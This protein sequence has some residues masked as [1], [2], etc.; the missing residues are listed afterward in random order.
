V[1]T[2]EAMRNAVVTHA[3]SDRPPSSSAIVRI[4]VPTTVWFS[5][6]KNIDT[7]MLRRTRWMLRLVRICEVTGWWARFFAMQKLPLARR[8]VHRIVVNR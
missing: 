2:V 1:L 4:A 7:M 8:T 6:D 5:A 3:C